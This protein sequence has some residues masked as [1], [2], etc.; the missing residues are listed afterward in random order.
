MP[1]LLD[2]LSPRPQ[3]PPADE[4]AAR[5]LQRGAAARTE[6]HRRTMHNA[7]RLVQANAIASLRADPVPEHGWSGGAY[8]QVWRPTHSPSRNEQVGPYAEYEQV[9]LE[10]AIVGPLCIANAIAST[11][12]ASVMP[13]RLCV[14]EAEAE[15]EAEARDA[16]IEPRR[17]VEECRRRA[18]AIAA[19]CEALMSGG[20]AEG[21]S[22][23][24]RALPFCELCACVSVFLP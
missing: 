19:A 22:H 6:V 14:A 18:R 17:V 16:T 15:A 9:P 13:L 23:G 4:A 20:R 8:V 21:H 10:A 3:T 5:T 1:G 11:R 24:L 7:E 2:A 12:M